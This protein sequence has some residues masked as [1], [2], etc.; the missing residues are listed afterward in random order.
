MSYVGNTPTQQGYSPA[1]DYFNGTGSQTAFTLSRPV[2]TT[3]QVIVVVNNVTQNP[4]TAYTV[5]G[6][7]ITFTGAPS[8]GTNNI[9][10]SYTSPIT[11]V[12]ALSQGP[13]VVGP[14]YVSINNAT[15]LGGA[16]NPILGT[17]GSANSY[18]QSYVL[19]QTNG[20][21]SS[22]DFTAY[23]SNGTDAAGWVDMGITSATFSQA[24]F[25]VTGPN[26]SYLFGSAPSGSGTTGNLVIA[27]DSTG[28]ANS[29]QFYTNG[30]NQAKSA[31]R[32]VIDGSTGNVGIGTSSPSSQN[33]VFKLVTGNSSAANSGSTIVTG[34]T[35]AGWLGWNNADSASIPAYVK[36]DFSN[37]AMSF[38]VNSAERARIDSSGNLLVGTASN[39][40][41]GRLDVAWDGTGNA[42]GVR[43]SNASF[44]GAAFIVYADR[45]T[46]NNTFKGMAYY[47]VGAGAYKFIVQDSGNVQNVN[48]SYGAI[49]DIKLKENIT[50]ATPK[51]A[52]LNQV[53]VVNYNL[54]GDTNKQI[55]VVAQ[56]LEQIF[57]SMIDEEIDRDAEGNDLGTTTKS[58]KYSVFVPMLIKAIQEQQA[59]ITTLTERITALEAK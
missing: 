8:V 23:P 10:V 35:G 24:A 26:E 54:I 20:A 28:T 36:Y 6:N 33:S 17:S 30:F 59:L 16:T 11:Q 47:N 45:N 39:Y 25:S 5:S 18:V 3:A 58:V 42:A 53:R 22:A 13:S 46:T 55:G 40:S 31:A 49:S 21:N 32:M 29:I 9:Y 15:P 48:N 4:S 19:N 14:M 52:Q 44:T 50:D 7:T 38:Q 51:L 34:S 27:T 56:E 12:N 37:N 57:P 43:A 1:I 2:A 41:G